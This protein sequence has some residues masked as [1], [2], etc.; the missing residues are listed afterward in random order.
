[1]KKAIL[2]FCMFLFGLGLSAQVATDQIKLNQLGF[3]THGPKLAIVTTEIPLKNFFVVS[4]ANTRDTVF[5][6][7][8][9]E[10]GKSLNSSVKT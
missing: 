5:K 1:M 2:I 7:P 10:L 8:L 6:A 3:Y 4:A 9:S